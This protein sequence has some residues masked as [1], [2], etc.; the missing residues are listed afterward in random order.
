M[1]IFNKQQQKQIMPSAAMPFE[2]KNGETVPLE[3]SWSII[4][5]L[6]VSRDESYPDFSRVL[7]KGSTDVMDNMRVLYA[8]YRGGY[9]NQN[10]SMD[11]AMAY[12]DFIGMVPDDMRSVMETV[13]ALLDPK[14]KRDSETLS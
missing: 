8:A 3:I 14:S 5:R 13:A 9:L 1:A 12:A 2:L 11:G 7:T 10:G 4:E 6:R